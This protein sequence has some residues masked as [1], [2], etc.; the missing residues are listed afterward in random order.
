MASLGEGDDPGRQIALISGNSK[1]IIVL[2]LKQDY[3][4]AHI[5]TPTSCQPS[6][7]RT[8][9]NIF[10]LSGISPIDNPA[11]WVIPRELNIFS[12]VGSTMEE[13]VL[14]ECVRVW[15]RCPALVIR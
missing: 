8:T 4:T 12:S 6:P 1:I 14:I 5:T 15:D 7:M 11:L 13:D 3:D 2:G 9:T 10:S